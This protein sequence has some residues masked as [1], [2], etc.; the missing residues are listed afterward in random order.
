[1][2]EILAHGGFLPQLADLHKTR[3][4]WTRRNGVVF[5]VLWCLFFL[6]ILT[7]LWGIADIDEMAAASAVIGI[8][9]GL[10]FLISSLTLLRK[11]PPAIDLLPMAKPAATPAGLYSKPGRSALPPNQTEPASGYVPPAGTWK[12]P[13]TGEFARPG[14]VTE[15]T[16]KLLQKDTNE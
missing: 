9:G 7:P 6:L 3:S 2:S 12:T 11:T 4:L 13:D 16:T 10:I 5:S 14:S 8:F 15:S 1:V